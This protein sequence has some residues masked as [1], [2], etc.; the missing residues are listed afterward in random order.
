MHTEIIKSEVLAL[1]RQTLKSN[2]VTDSSNFFSLG[3]QSLQAVQ[4]VAEIARTHKKVLSLRDFFNNPSVN[5]IVDLLEKETR[6]ADSSQDA[7]P[8]MAIAT[9][10]FIGAT[11]NANFEPF[12]L[13]EVQHAYWIGRSS[14]FEMGNIATHVYVEFQCDHLEIEKFQVAWNK[15][16][17]RHDML[18]AVI[19]PDGEQHVLESHSYQIAVLDLT[20][21]DLPAASAEQMKIRD[22]MSHQVL[23][24][25]KPL[26]EIVASQTNAGIRLHCS[27]DLLI[28]DLWSTQILFRDLEFFYK[29]PSGDLP[30]LGFTF[31]DYV[32]AEQTFGRGE[33]FSKAENYWQRRIEGFPRGPVLPLRKKPSSVKSPKFT[34]RSATLAPSTWQAL[35]KYAEINSLTPSGLLAAAYAEI[36]SLWSGSR[37]FALNLTLFNRA[38]VHPDVADIIGDFTSLSLLEI[39]TASRESFIDRAKTI[40]T[41]LWDDLDH[42][43]YSGL[44]V[45]REYSKFHGLTEGAFPVV[46]TSALMHGDTVS[47]EFIGE[48]IYQISQTPQIWLDHQ[49]FEEAGALVFNW[50]AVEELFPD[51]MLDDMFDAYQGLL[52]KL[53]RHPSE[54]PDV[55]PRWQTDLYA[56][57]NSTSQALPSDTLL[58]LFLK[59]ASSAGENP[60]V[61]GGKVSL[62]YE[63]LLRRAQHVARQLIL[64]GAKRGDM[65]PVIMVKGWEQ[66]VA[67]LAIHYIGAAYVPIDAELPAE[68][69]NKLLTQIAAKTV[70]V[71]EH[72]SFAAELP[73]HLQMIQIASDAPADPDSLPPVRGNPED[74]AYVIFT[75][76]STGE[77]KGVMIDHLG[78]VNTILDIN[79]KISIAPSDT[80]LGISSLSFDLSVYDIFGT[81]AAGATLVLPEPHETKDARCWL[82]LM[83]DHHVTI[84]NSV[85]ALMNMLVEYRHEA[86]ISAKLPLRVALLSGDWIPVGLPQK[87]SDA[88]P[89]CEIVSL[90]GATEASIWSIYYPI[91]EVDAAAKSIPYGYPLSN[92]TFHVL[93]A[94]C[95]PVPVWVPGELYI[96]GAGLAK[97]YHADEKKTAA[98]FV[99]LP[100][101]SGR[102]Y[103]TGDLGRYLPNGAIE[104]LGR[105]DDQI[106]IGGHRIELGEIEATLC[107]FP[108]VKNAIA[109]VYGE[110]KTK[111]K[112]AAFVFSDEYN[113]RL[114][115]LKTDPLAPDAHFLNTL[116]QAG[117]A[118]SDAHPNAIDMENWSR[119][120]GNLDRLIASRYISL[121]ARYRLFE[122]RGNT[123][124]FE[125]ILSATGTPKRYKVWM[126]RLLDVLVQDNWL[127]RQGDRY[128]CLRAFSDTAQELEWE[129]LK[130]QAIASRI[131]IS[132]IQF[133]ERSA[134][135][136]DTTL[137]GKQEAV[138]LLFGEGES[139]QAVDMYEDEFSYC[140]AIVKALF[141]QYSE[142]LRQSPRKDRKI[143]I[144]ELGA[145]IGSS[146]R[147]V[148]PAISDL[149]VEYHYTDISKY[150][151]SFGQEQFSEYGFIDFKLL[152]I[153]RSPASQ[154]F[155]ENGYDIVLAA[156]VLHATRDLE[157]TLGNVKKLLAPGGLLV[158]I[159][160]TKFPRIFNFTM[161]LQQ[162]FDR[163]TDTRLRQ[164]HPLLSFPQWEN[165]LASQGYGVAKRYVNE[166]TTAGNLGL[167]V[168]TAQGPMAVCTLQERALTAYLESS[169]PD[170]MV[171]EK[172][173]QIEHIPLSGNGKVR[174]DMLPSPWLE[175]K[176]KT[177]MNP[178]KTVLE[179]RLAALFEAMLATSAVGLDD[180]FFDLGGDSLLA[181]KMVAKIRTEF[182]VV[183]SIRTI[184]ETPTVSGLARNIE[185]TSALAR[186]SA[187]YL[188]A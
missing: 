144:L 69:R 45:M 56:N 33:N 27:L 183:L 74:L 108:G 135:A 24:S 30:A 116:E 150:F 43:E 177:L 119:I 167:E 51:R 98:A 37:H 31:R 8:P 38:P 58:D 13:N 130:E 138:S 175:T 78:A 117:I 172:I 163:F 133:A 181:T 174:K 128:I 160:E 185:K 134:K 113:E 115:Q 89:E 180:N 136:L 126:L 12:P 91:H 11:G 53:I 26:Y 102:Y 1:F 97:G 101:K 5:G 131:P 14:F 94:E 66:V 159:E 76:G 15:V 114:H 17:A 4:L 121:L 42:R 152:D 187:S 157:E 129:K 73:G 170:Y 29:N 61:K 50:D 182:N 75:S 137:S 92:Q 165:L 20:Q 6:A 169:L 40:Q 28:A 80:V 96:G 34:R 10:A 107:K 125:E 110:S 63:G 18:R 145:G 32:L 103:K 41:Q 151:L 154:G 67:V 156:S 88:A 83:E 124:T 81:L 84:W 173:I 166:T 71:Q 54:L 168:I 109:N 141:R 176:K 39:N 178:P 186:A 164:H 93:D 140:N 3:G 46:F 123:Y 111:Q 57:T 155:E 36:L 147:H 139:Q 153:E 21:H 25:S 188:D 48:I 143:K 62:S 70:L 112:L 105:K 162:G 184:F 85:P 35:K 79:Q 2:A 65:I 16:C 158:L 104:F 100:E 171:P 161:G 55:L 127:E 148:L 132:G 142:N 7:L 23:D 99:S 22:R 68:R 95:K 49:V 87:I 47:T 44:K 77:P 9:P 64:A 86:H 52:H 19:T 179:K 90:G 149:E 72:N 118:A 82:S 122:T 146:T 60:A 120:Y 59:R 106:K